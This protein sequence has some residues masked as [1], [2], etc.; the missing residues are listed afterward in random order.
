MLKKRDQRYIEQAVKYIG[1]Y[2]VAM[3]DNEQPELE[4]LIEQDKILDDF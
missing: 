2:I 1:E 4:K 3:D